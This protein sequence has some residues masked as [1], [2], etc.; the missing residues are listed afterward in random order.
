LGEVTRN[1]RLAHAENFLELGNRELLFF[2]KQEQAK[3]GR[4]RE[5]AKKINS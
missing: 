5:Q 2:Q 1:A 3:P 4:V